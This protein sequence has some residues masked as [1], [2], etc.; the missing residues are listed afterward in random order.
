V[1][2]R[3]RD[4]DGGSGSRPIPTSLKGVEEQLQGQ[5]TRASDVPIAEAGSAS[6]ASHA[7]VTRVSPKEWAAKRVRGVW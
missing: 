1:L 6:P 2:G 4:D 5:A 3:D 7:A